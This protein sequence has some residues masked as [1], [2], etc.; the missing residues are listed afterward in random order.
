LAA[1]LLGWL[2]GNCWQGKA[3][4]ILPH[5]DKDESPRGGSKSGDQKRLL[6]TRK[7]VI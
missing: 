7:A 1:R 4:K 2:L 6:S 5:R 3:C